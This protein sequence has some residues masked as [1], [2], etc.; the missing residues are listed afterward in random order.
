MKRMNLRIAAAQMRSTP[1]VE[2]NLKKIYHLIQSAKK[3]E[4]DL[5]AFPENCLLMGYGSKSFTHNRNLVEKVALP[6]IQKWAFEFNIAIVLGGVA[7]SNPRSNKFF[8]RLFFISEKGKIIGHYDKIHLFDSD[9]KGER[10][11]RESQYIKAGRESKYVLWKKIKFGLSICYDLRFPELYRFLSKKG[12][13]VFFIPAAFTYPTG[14][15]HWDTL[16]KS[17]AIENLSFVIAPAQEGLHKNKRKTYGHTRIIDPWGKNLTEKKKGVGIIYSDID[18]D[19]LNKTRQSFP[20][21]KH[22]KF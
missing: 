4:A 21:L 5:I 13:H 6:L 7:V 10:P 16:T 18:L 12:A 14:K 22:R 8:N 11:Y 15:A 17:R 20:T 19:F 1:N 3:G 2:E 9:L